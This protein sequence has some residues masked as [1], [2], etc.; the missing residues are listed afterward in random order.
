MAQ[1]NKVIEDYNAQVEQL[2]EDS[3]ENPRRGTG[4]Q[5]QSF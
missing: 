1:Q 3:I 4:V 2:D 5:Q